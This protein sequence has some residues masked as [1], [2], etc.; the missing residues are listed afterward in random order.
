MSRP[1]IALL[2]DFGLDDNFVGVMKGVIARYCPD[3]N[4]IDISNSIPRHSVMHAALVLLGSYRHFPEGTIFTVVVDPGVGTDRKIL[5]VRTERYTFIAPDN[6]C[7]SPVA[8]ESAG[9][10]FYEVTYRPAVTPSETFCG[11]DVFAPV[12]GMLASGGAVE[13]IAR[14][15]PSIAQ[16]DIPQA[17]SAVQG[18]I[19]GII[20]YIDSFGNAMSNIPRDMVGGRVKVRAA[21]VEIEGVSK[22]YAENEPGSALAIFNSYDMLEIAVNRGSA[23]E[24]LGIKEGMEVIVEPMK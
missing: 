1:V 13:E 22:S 5:V 23:A 9:A 14:E 20:L 24:K 15:I 6:R 21:G 18:G 8:R 3:A 10:K 19:A 17:H 12:A 11:R 4:V 2:T 16:F 7:L